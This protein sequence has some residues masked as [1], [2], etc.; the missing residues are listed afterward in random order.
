MNDSAPKRRWFRFSL[1]G[2][3]I[4]IAIASVPL[5]WVGWSLNRIRQRHQFLAAYSS[6][7]FVMN[8][9]AD[10][11]FAPMGLWVFGEVGIDRM[12]LDLGEDV[13]DAVQVIHYAKS[14]FPEA[15]LNWSYYD[16]DGTRMGGE[17][18]DLP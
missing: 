10:R 7:L 18:P 6:A 8:M 1:R 5:A 17:P 16:Q 12:D 13:P 9:E 2:L 14:I 11:N 4:A 15:Y 3:V